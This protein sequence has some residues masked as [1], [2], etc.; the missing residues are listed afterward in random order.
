MTANLMCHKLGKGCE[1]G[2]VHKINIWQTLLTLCHATFSHLPRSQHIALQLLPLYRQIGLLETSFR[3]F[4]GVKYH[5]T[6]EIK[7]AC[8]TFTFE[9]R[10]RVWTTRVQMDQSNCSVWRLFSTHASSEQNGCRSSGWKELKLCFAARERALVYNNA[11]G[12]SQRKC[13]S[14]WRSDEGRGD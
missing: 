1:E 13:S 12:H 2:H 4:L 11:G 9:R 5:K 6:N 7:P 14:Y 3:P 8:Q 10:T